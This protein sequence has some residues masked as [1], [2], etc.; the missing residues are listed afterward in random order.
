[1]LAAGMVVEVLRR[2]DE[3]AVRSAVLEALAPYRT[4]AGTYRLDNEWH[5]LIAHA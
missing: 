4:P 5:Y 1:M 2:H 3:A